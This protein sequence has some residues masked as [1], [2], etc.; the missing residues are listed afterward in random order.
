MYVLSLSVM[1]YSLKPHGLQPTMEFFRQEDQSG[2]P[3]PPPRNLPNPG[4]ELAS[5]A[6]PALAGG[7]FTTNA[8]WRTPQKNMFCYPA[9]VCAC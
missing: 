8:T 9:C 4:I 7:F 6:S 3:F 5:L 1:S 2:V